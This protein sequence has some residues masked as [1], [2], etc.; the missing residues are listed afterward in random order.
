[1]LGKEA[2]DESME[3]LILDKRVFVSKEVS[4]NI[5]IAV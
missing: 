5:L 1:V 2:Y 3:V 4:K